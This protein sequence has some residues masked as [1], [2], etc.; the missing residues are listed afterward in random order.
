MRGTFY[1]DD[2]RLIP[3]ELPK[4]QTAVLEAR[5]DTEPETFHL[6]QN[7]PNPFNSGTVIRF[8]LPQRRILELSIYSLAGQKVTTLI[9]GLRPAGSYTVRWDGRDAAGYA[10]ASG[11]YFYRLTTDSFVQTRRM[12][13]MK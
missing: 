1:L 6:D 8:D 10:L 3:Q 5:R 4:Q 2:I 9:D 13:L 7:Y 12:V 11:L